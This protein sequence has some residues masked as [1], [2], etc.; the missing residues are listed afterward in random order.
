MKKYKIMALVFAVL[1]G[2]ATLLF[3]GSLQNSVHKDYISVVVTTKYIT[4]QTK[5][6]A[7]MLE[8]K[9]LPAEAVHPDAARS[10]SA[11]TGKI[12]DGVLEKGETVLVSKLV[13]S[14]GNTGNFSYRIPDGMRA[15]TIRVDA[16][17]GTGGLIKAGDRVDILVEVEQQ[18]AGNVDKTPTSTMLLQNIEV[19]AT[20]ADSGQNSG[21]S[22]TTVTL[23][24]SRN[25]DLLK[26][27]LAAI[28]GKM[29]L[30]LRSPL[31]K[32]TY[33]Y[34]AQTIQDLK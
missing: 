2:L 16:V 26:L 28:A 32:G 3:F 34:H 18:T 10:I 20:G 7:E 27:N 11:V 29:R 13:A 25:D 24:V 31:D 12:T 19:L 23:S 21:G 5:L 17:T 14:G 15:V 33:T 22:Y 8:L 1:T 6:T 4:K 30:T 9:K